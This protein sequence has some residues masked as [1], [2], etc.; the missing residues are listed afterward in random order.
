MLETFLFFLKLGYSHV[1]DFDGLDHF[2]FLVVMTLPFALDEWKLLF[3]W[4]TLFTTGHCL[5][6]FVNHYFKLQIDYYWIEILIPITITYSCISILLKFN[7][8]GKQD[9]FKHFTLLTLFFG[10]IH[11]L[12]FG[13]YFNQIVQEDSSF[14]SLLGFAFGVE[15]AQLIIVAI[16]VILN[17]LIIKF[18]NEKFKL[19]ISGGSFMILI[20]SLKM[21]FERL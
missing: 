6:L 19:W 10:L 2:Y 8:F 9:I 14:I 4:V 16:V 21:V 1:L 15:F 20:L 5:T 13:R 17:V 12:G 18:F 11:G 7:G 3:K